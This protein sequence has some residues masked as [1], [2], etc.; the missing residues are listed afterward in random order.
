M[1]RSVLF[2]LVL[3]PGL[4][5]AGPSTQTFLAGAKSVDIAGPVEVPL[6]VGPQTD[7]LPAVWATLPKAG[8]A[9]G[10]PVPAALA[11]IDLGSRYTTIS[12]GLAG[13]LGLKVKQGKLLGNDE[14]KY[15][16]IAEIR[17]GDVV[18]R[19]VP[20]L[21]GGTSPALSL[22]FGTFEELGVAILPSKGAVKLVPAAQAAALVQEVGAPLS[23]ARVTDESWFEHGTK[24][25]GNGLG[26]SVAGKV[27]GKDGQ[28]LLT[29][30]RA[31][32]Y[33]AAE[34]PIP[35]ARTLRGVEGAVEAVSLG[36]IALPAT[37]VMHRGQLV[38]ATGAIVGAAG[39][40]ALYAYDIA[41][42]PAGGKAALKRAEVPKSVD[43]A[44]LL[45]AAARA[46]FEHASKSDAGE[47]AQE[48]EE[49]PAHDPGKPKVV[50]RELAFADALSAA[51]KYDEAVTHYRAAAAAAGDVCKPYLA[52]GR[53]LLAGGDAKGALEPLEKAGSLWS[54]WY[55]Q[56]LDTRLAIKDGKFQG[57]GFTL[58]QPSECHEAW[59]SLAA[60]E[61]ALGNYAK[62]AEIH[63]KHTDLDPHV[64]L[65]YALGLLAQGQ[66]DAARGP[67]Q[68]AINLGQRNGTSV[69]AALALAEPEL[70]GDA[71]LNRWLQSEDDAAQVQ[72]FAIV[73]A[74]RRAQGDA[75]V[76]SMLANAV[77]ADPLSL[78]AAMLAAREAARGEAVAAEAVAA[79]RSV[80]EA[81]LKA[82][83][84]S[85]PNSGV[86]SAYLGVARA[87]SGDAEGAKAAVESA[88][89]ADPRLATNWVAAA[90]V[91]EILGD[92]DG[93]K[94][95]L[96]EL[97]AH[98]PL[99]AA[100]FVPVG[101]G[102]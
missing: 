96:E 34:T 64:P 31:Q 74:T 98:A 73:E 44:E 100:A 59:G 77:K 26:F 87:L 60:A 78:Q 76:R 47:A 94:S 41:L 37:W 57:E 23:V 12:S 35:N 51:R 49:A 38:D 7:F 70:A 36:E 52:L 19:E 66:A 9:E 86:A 90:L 53:A 65:A 97:R 91:A 45:L 101:T 93:A 85:R 54:R 72:L 3:V 82:Y 2:T 63:A 39:Y 24:K 16:T 42:D 80:F 56:P 5:F 46:E 67:L 20:A 1:P 18:L 30:D 84:E 75:G 69:R 88:K 13:Q 95:A 55:Q 8:A 21:V 61:L 81:R 25:Y 99:S 10:E 29:T 62:V 6:A 71:A 15:T 43:P 50:S 27:F 17:V 22:G 102:G 14:Q 28:V 40:D 33:A 4:A 32:S 92:A 79:A 83:G 89:V 48:G 68:E 58:E 11:I